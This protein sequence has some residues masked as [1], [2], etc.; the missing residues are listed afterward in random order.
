[1]S[2]RKDR[3]INGLKAV[4]ECLGELIT[5]DE[6]VVREALTAGNDLNSF[7]VQVNE[8]LTEAHKAAVRECIQN[9]DKLTDLH[10]QILACDLVFERLEKM[11]LGFQGDLGTISDDMKRLQ[12]Q[13]GPLKFDSFGVENETLFN[14]SFSPKQTYIF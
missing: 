14:L 2:V 3:S 5:A 6:S 11:L 10:N 8:E 13:S 12:E 7:S 1:M 9:A 4:E